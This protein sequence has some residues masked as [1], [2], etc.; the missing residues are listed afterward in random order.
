MKAVLTNKCTKCLTCLADCPVRIIT[1]NTEGFPVMKASSKEACI[2]CGHCDALCPQLG[3]GITSNRLE[4][5][6][7]ILGS[8]MKNRR[9]IRNYKDQLVDKSMLNEMLDVVRYAPSGHNDQALQWIIVHNT[10]EL[11]RLAAVVIEWMRQ[12]MKLGEPI[13]RKLNFPILVRA[14]KQGQDIICWNAPHLVIAL[15]PKEKSTDAAIALAH[16]EL[17]AP[18]YGLGTC[19]AG[20]FQIAVMHSPELK[21]ALG[22]P[23]SDE[24]LGSMMIGYPKFKYYQVPERK[25]ARITWR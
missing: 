25:E 12:S 19:W 8:Y 23:K 3:E 10:K 18:T 9:S 1:V 22:V 13:A 24:V 20:F 7:E 2:H 14:Y 11:R 21:Q 15:G 4:L 16:L 17:L 5:T 6:P